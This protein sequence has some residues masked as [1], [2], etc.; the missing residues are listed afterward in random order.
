MPPRGSGGVVLRAPG[1]GGDVIR[2]VPSDWYCTCYSYPPR[3]RRPTHTHT[4]SCWSR[5]SS[6]LSSGCLCTASQGGD[7]RGSLVVTVNGGHPGL[8]H[9]V[10]GVRISRE[11]GRVLGY[12]LGRRLLDGVKALGCLPLNRES[13][14][15][16]IA[17][18]QAQ[19]PWRAHC[20]HGRPH[21]SC[22]LIPLSRG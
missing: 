1:Y 4:T 5:P 22:S 12:A 14:P 2:G 8:V 3:N 16:K 18:L 15:P 13:L 19:Q 11:V 21:Q 6:S 7:L 20:L 9:L 10:H 17:S